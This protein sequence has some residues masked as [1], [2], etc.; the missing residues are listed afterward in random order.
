AVSGVTARW[1]SGL[2]GTLTVQIAPEAARTPLPERVAAAVAL[3][4]D[5][6]G[7]ARAEPLPED[8]AA[9]LLSPWLGEGVEGLDL[10]LPALIDVT[11]AAPGAIDVAALRTRLQA[12]PGAGVDDH[13]G[14]MADIAR[15]A[16]TVELLAGGIVALIAAAAVLAVVFAARAGLAIHRSTVELLH[17]MGAPDPYVAGQF[18]RHALRSAALGGVPGAALGVLTLLALR[19]LAARLDAVALP[20]FVLSAGGWLAVLAVPLAAAAIA[21][22]TA[23]LTALRTLGRMP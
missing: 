16:G 9:D 17:V 13:S 6:P 4:R 19:G 23:R 15:L 20:D 11:A 3:L 21:A 18:Q 12:V 10:P 2:A 7:V 1:Q 8:A 5:A 22:V 14:W